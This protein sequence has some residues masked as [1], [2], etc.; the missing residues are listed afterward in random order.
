MELPKCGNGNEQEFGIL[1]KTLY[2][3]YFFNEELFTFNYSK[4]GIGIYSSDQKSPACIPVNDHYFIPL[5]NDLKCEPTCIYTIG[6]ILSI[7][8]QKAKPCFSHPFF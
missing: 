4:T 3:F 7:I 1:P 2:S 8:A 6:C 5:M